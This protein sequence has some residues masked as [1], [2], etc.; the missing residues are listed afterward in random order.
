MTNRITHIRKSTWNYMY[1]LYYA[2]TRHNYREIVIMS[3]T[4]V[5]VLSHMQYVLK[6]STQWRAVSVYMNS[7]PPINVA[8]QFVVY[9]N[10]II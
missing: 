4:S 10:N 9:I 5:M 3:Y 7:E 8:H 2:H 1:I 6:H